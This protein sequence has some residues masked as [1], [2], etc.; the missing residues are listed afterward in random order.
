[1][2]A[3]RI[4]ILIFVFLVLLSASPWNEVLGQRF[5][6]HDGKG[7]MS[8]LT[9]EQRQAVN[10]KVIELRD[11]GATREEI[12]TAVAEIL[13]G[14]G[15][16]LPEDWGEGHRGGFRDFMSNLTDEQRQAV[17]EKIKEMKDQGSTR[18]EI[19]TAVA[20]MLEGYGIEVP[21]DWPGPFGLG[22]GPGGF[23]KDL[24]KEQR[25]AVHEKIKE[26]KDQGATREEI[27]TAVAE[28]LEGY[29]I[30]LP[31]DWGEGHRGGFRDFIS[32]LT[33]EQRQAVHEKVKEMRSQGATR[34]EIRAAIAEM[35][36]EYGI[37]LPKD[38]EDSTSEIAPAAQ[39]YIKAQNYPNPFNPQTE[40][41]YSLPE[42][43][44]VK[45]TILNIQGQKVRVLVDEYQ[46]AGMKKVTWD[47]CDES[48]ERVASGVYFY[49]IEA[50]PY[51][52]TKQMVLLK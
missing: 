50:G 24:T 34:E 36:E 17:H 33:D 5:G 20:E 27:W 11:Q 14:Y 7:F 35:L 16:E 52:V 28:I 3:Y 2:K 43:S 29:G 38:S 1:M 31:E 46:S 18:E 21:E 22:H 12:R 4:S 44:K 47:G 23:W 37:E 10:E 9:Q 13:E 40:I 19:R 48:G 42:N 25:E 30:E 39:P 26:M 41:A 8:N 45:L 49:R 51:D 6:G 15:I 32:N